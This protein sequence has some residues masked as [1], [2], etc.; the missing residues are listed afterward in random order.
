MLIRSR[1]TSDNKRIKQLL[2]V[3]VSLLVVAFVVPSVVRFVAGVVLYPVIQ[4][5]NWFATSNQV[6]PTLWRDKIELQTEINSLKQE[7]ASSGR[8][9]LTQQRLFA[10]NNRL[11][12]L[13]GATTSSRVAAAVVG[14][15]TELPYDLIQI[16]QGYVAGIE[17]GAPVFIGRDTVIGI[18]STVQRTSA[19]VTLFTTP[20]FQSTVFLSDANVVAI[21][22]GLGGGVARVRVPQGIPLRINDL[23][24][25]PSIQP[26]VYGRIAW[27]ENEPTQPE[28][29][30]YI[31]P[32]IP[33]TSL[34]MVS[35]GE[36][37]VISD[38]PERAREYMA[39]IQ[40]ELLVIPQITPV[41]LATS[42]ASTTETVSTSE[43]A[44]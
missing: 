35:V 28:Q 1:R 21:L 2:L 36:P 32:E 43:E 41:T 39:E 17:V 22:E 7:I 6:L 9:D 42:T 27:V 15:P 18:V 19:F 8:E 3:V 24:H 26:G 40:K 14:R 5:E 4:I 44:S 16:D 37:S 38:D 34:Y 23:V 30:G 10:E 13:L 31:T 29:Y 11:R 20:D 25:I 12:A 33:I